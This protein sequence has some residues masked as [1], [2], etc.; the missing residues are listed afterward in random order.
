MKQTSEQDERQ[1]HIILTDVCRRVSLHRGLSQST[2]T[3]EAGFNICALVLMKQ[4]L[5]TLR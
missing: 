2:T 1:I 5:L 4:V 3:G